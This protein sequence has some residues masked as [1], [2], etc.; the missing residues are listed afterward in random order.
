MS[1][2]PPPAL[3]ERSPV[4]TDWIHPVRRYASAVAFALAGLIATAVL[5][6][7]VAE[8][9]RERDRQRFEAECLRIVGMIEQKMERYE[10]ALSRLQDAC[11]R[12]KGRPSR[13]VWRH[14]LES[15]LD[16]RDNYP[17]LLMLAVAARNPPS[18]AASTNTPNLLLPQPEEDSPVLTVIRRNAFADLSLKGVGTNLAVQ[19]AFHPD[20]GR[21]LHRTFGWVDDRVWQLRRTNGSPARGFWFAIPLRPDDQASPPRWRLEHETKEEA[22]RRRHSQLADAA[23]GVLAAFIGGEEFLGEFNRPSSQALV[24]LQLYTSANALPDRL[25]NPAH[26]PPQRPRF[27]SDIVMSWYARRWTARFASTPLFDAQSLRYRAV[28]VW[29]LGIPLSLTGAG[30]LAWQTSSRWREAEL[31]ARLRE[32]LARQERLSRDL[33]DGTL[34]SVYGIGLALHRTRRHLERNPG[35]AAQ[36]LSDTILALQR[37]I[38]ELRAFIRESDPSDR[39]KIPLGEALEGVVSHL[40]PATEMEIVLGIDAGADAG[41][42]PGRALQLLNIAREAISNSI[43]HSHGRRIQIRLQRTPDRLRLVVE[44]DGAGFDPVASEALGR[45][46]R[47][48][49]ARIREL[50]GERSWDSHPGGGSRLTVEV[51]ITAPPSSN[52]PA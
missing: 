40:R 24:G 12:A 23:S 34:Q 22:Q 6:R 26:T 4:G 36:P 28:L 51:P 43:R 11:A 32:A 8:W 41:I 44:D 48:L 15:V 16:V 30:A 9:A 25:L 1:D 42:D 3:P 33:H 31:A 29:A 13:A 35:D 19:T 45:G 10:T 46:L 20:F 14:W 18:P 39:I 52:R 27:Q 37:V 49:T 17:S 7:Q 5:G 21:T 2:R 50:D 38:E 47:N